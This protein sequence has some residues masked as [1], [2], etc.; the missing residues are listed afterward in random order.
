MSVSAL[1][2]NQWSGMTYGGYA[3]SSSKGKESGG[4]WIAEVAPELMKAEAEKRKANDENAAKPLAPLTYS[5]RI[6]AKFKTEELIANN[7][8]NGE[9]IYSYQASAQQF[10]IMINVNG[11]ERKYFIKGIDGEGNVFEKEFDPYEVDPEN[12]D[13]TEF[14][15]L[16]LYIQRTDGYA[17]SLMSDFVQPE[18]I[19]EKRNYFGILET[20]GNEQAQSGNPELYD[21]AMRMLIAIRAFT[22]KSL[23]VSGKNINITFSDKG[24]PVSAEAVARLF[25]DQDVI[26]AKKIEKTKGTYSGGDPQKLPKVFY[27]YYS[28]EGMKCIREG[29]RN[30]ADPEEKIGDDTLQWE[31]KFTDPKQYD[32][33]MEFLA[34]FPEEDNFRFAA[35][36]KFWNDFLHGKVDMEGFR[37]FY[38]WTDHGVPHMNKTEEGGHT[39]IN[40]ERILNPNSG[41]FNDW[42]WIRNVWTEEEMWANWY[43]RIGKSASPH[44]VDKNSP[45]SSDGTNPVSPIG[46]K[47]TPREYREQAFGQ[48]GA[49]A[50]KSVK[51]AWL[52]AADVAGMDGM[53]ISDLG[54]LD[55]IP[56]FLI[57]RWIRG[58]RGENVYDMLGNSV[59][60]AIHAASEALY[61]LEH[62]LEPNR[63]RTTKELMNI[64]KERKFYQ[65]FISRLQ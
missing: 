28:P 45:I 1:L 53:G 5:R 38:A 39:G 7:T 30:P 50:P 29:E 27:T 34:E 60:S 13:Y 56:Q 2:T 19:L 65:E 15:A 33:V 20:W 11:D 44:G 12:T 59:L 42:T 57:Q 49:N 55:H 58:M 8:E 46:M 51:Q 26:H 23:S 35:N 9:T 25:E 18:N 3:K 62:P 36:E 54:A 10:E 31:I 40:R 52:D 47:K 16:C 4:K 41:Y 14:T 6:S 43:A 61:E 21:N 22:E 24:T 64:E 63:V 32:R 17:D 48:I 37:E